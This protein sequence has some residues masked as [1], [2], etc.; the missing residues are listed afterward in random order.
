KNLVHRPRPAAD[1]ENGLFGPLFSVDHGSF[2]S[3]HSITVGFV[4]VG[5]AA[6]IT[7]GNRLI[8]WCIAP[9]L[10][11]GIVWQRTLI[12]A[13]WLSDTLFGVIA[14]AAGT[15]IVWWAFWP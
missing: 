12:N 9:L 4:I 5:V 14:G 15:L 11:V 6:L 8:W 10:A 2:P 7:P 1:I 13:H 3:G